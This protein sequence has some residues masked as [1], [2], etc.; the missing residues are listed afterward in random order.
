L[1]LKFCPGS[2]IFLAPPLVIAEPKM[3]TKKLSFGRLKYDIF[4]GNYAKHLKQFASRVPEEIGGN[5]QMKRHKL[6]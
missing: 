6:N 3:S 2:S 5:I 1:W 4:N